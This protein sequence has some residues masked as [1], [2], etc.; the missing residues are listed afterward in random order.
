MIPHRSELP[1]LTTL[2]SISHRPPCAFASCSLPQFLFHS[3]NQFQLCFCL[4][5]RSSG[6][7]SLSAFLGRKGGKEEERGSDDKR[8]HRRRRS[9][10]S[11]L[12]KKLRGRASLPEPRYCLS[13]RSLPPPSSPCYLG[14]LF[15][16]RMGGRE[17]T[18]ISH[19]AGKYWLFG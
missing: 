5:A 15:Q 18:D 13:L 11:I 1:T 8:R 4:L 12:H 6:R 16:Q 14:T 17:G 19:E 3:R 10:P 2:S 9:R 7:R